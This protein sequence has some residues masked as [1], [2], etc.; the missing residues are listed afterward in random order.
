MYRL[1]NQGTNVAI[2]SR[3][4]SWPDDRLEDL[5]MRKSVSHSLTLVMPK[6]TALSDRLK[7]GGATVCYYG[8]IYKGV[9]NTRFTLINLERH[10]TVLA[11]GRTNDHVHRIERFSDQSD[12]A[13]LMAEDMFKLIK[14]I[15]STVDA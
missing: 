6:P 4:M 1:I 13:L 7:D 14:E 9:I 15:E 2:F 3:D 5:L 10:S 12:P 8:N 11:V